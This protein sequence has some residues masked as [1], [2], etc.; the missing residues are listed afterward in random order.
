MVVCS[1]DATRLLLCVS[2]VPT[3][4]LRIRGILQVLLPRLGE[5][6]LSFVQDDG[7]LKIKNQHKS[8]V[9]LNL[10]SSVRAEHGKQ[11]QENLGRAVGRR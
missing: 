10:Y 3:A 9:A 11:V 2:A 5:L 6:K 7:N 8:H 1:S 4:V